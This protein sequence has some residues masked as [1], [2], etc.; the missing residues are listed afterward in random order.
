MFGILAIVAMLVTVVTY[1]LRPQPNKIP[2]ATLYASTG[3]IENGMEY[4][5]VCT[6]LGLQAEATWFDK[7]ESGFAVWRF[8]VSDVRFD[9]SRASFFVKFQEGAVVS[10]MLLYP[11]HAAG[12]GMTF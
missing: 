1:I 10:T 9:D 5:E 8:E 12:G 11:L 2:E 7:S 6:S 4:R 3:G